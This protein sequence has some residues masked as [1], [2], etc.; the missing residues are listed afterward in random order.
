MNFI[1]LTMSYNGKPVTI[2]IEEISFFTSESASLLESTVNAYTKIG[3]K[4]Q[5]E[6]K[7][8]ESHAEIQLAIDTAKKFG[9]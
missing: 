1:T 3:L 8:R 7:V 5:Y 9:Y 6:L 2:N 4:R